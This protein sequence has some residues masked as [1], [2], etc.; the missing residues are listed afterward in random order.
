MSESKRWQSH[1]GV[2]LKTAPRWPPGEATPCLQASKDMEEWGMPLCPTSP[3]NTHGR[4]FVITNCGCNEFDI[5][6]VYNTAWFLFC[7]LCQWITIF[8]LEIIS[9]IS[10]PPI[11]HE[12]ILKYQQCT[13]RAAGCPSN[14]SKAQGLPILRIQVYMGFFLEIHA[15]YYYLR[16]FMKCS[17]EYR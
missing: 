3:K 10:F 7:S 6:H 16:S 17:T 11:F 12:N 2:R 15:G 13:T 9:I 1:S 8:H 14:M 4:T 5:L